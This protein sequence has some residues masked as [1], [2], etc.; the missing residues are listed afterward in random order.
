MKLL[1]ITLIYFLLFVSEFAQSKPQ[2]IVDSYGNTY[3]QVSADENLELWVVDAKPKYKV[4]RPRLPQLD[5]YRG[6]GNKYTAVEFVESHMVESSSGYAI[7]VQD[8]DS[9]IA[10]HLSGARYLNVYFNGEKLFSEKID[11]Q[12]A[13]NF[14]LS[15]DGKYLIINDKYNYMGS[16]GRLRV[17]T[18]GSD[19]SYHLS[20]Q[21]AR[22]SEFWAK[23]TDSPKR[24]VRTHQLSEDGQFLFFAFTK[25]GT[26]EATGFWNV[27]SVEQSGWYMIDLATQNKFYITGIAYAQAPCLSQFL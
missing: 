22:P 18:Q 24:A 19:L 7:A 23:L 6:W 21:L 16:A 25:K 26:S 5:G 8:G 11:K 20:Y 27:S 10:K 17:Y 9:F 12:F 14:S 13:A 1:S 2:T 15:K 3:D 4:E